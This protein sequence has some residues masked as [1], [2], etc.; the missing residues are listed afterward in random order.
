MNKLQ[1]GNGNLIITAEKIKKLGAK[2][3]KEIDSKYLSDNS[4]ENE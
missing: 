1:H 2:T 3:K 4:L